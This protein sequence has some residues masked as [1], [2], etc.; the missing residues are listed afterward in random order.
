MNKILVLL[1]AAAGGFILNLMPC[2]F[3]VLSLKALSIAGNTGQRQQ[4]KTDA[5]WY[6]LGVVLSFLAL[7]AVL[8][9]LR[10]AGAAVGWGFQLQSPLLVAAL[11]YLLFYQLL[12]LI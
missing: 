10:A 3:P 2:V 5:L 7:A 1:M 4:Q 9:A 12:G 6:S 11:A 8:L